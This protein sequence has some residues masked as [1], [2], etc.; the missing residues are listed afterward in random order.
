M[1][2]QKSSASTVTGINP[3]VRSTPLF[4]NG[5]NFF[6]STAAPRE[7]P[8]ASQDVTVATSHPLT[9]PVLGTQANM[10]TPLNAF[11][12][13]HISPRGYK[14]ESTINAV[15]DVL[16]S[17]FSTEAHN[18]TWGSYE[19]SPARSDAWRL[20]LGLPQ[21][22]QT[23][24]FSQYRPS[25]SSENK[26]YLSI[27]NMVQRL[28]YDSNP[29]NPPPASNVIRSIVSGVQ[30]SGGRLAASDAGFDPSE[31]GEGR[32]AGSEGTS[33]RGFTLAVLGRYSWSRGADE[34]GPYIAYYD[35]YDLDQ[36][37]E[38]TEGKFG[39]PFE[40][41]GR[42]YYD[43]QTFEP[44]PEQNPLASMLQSLSSSRSR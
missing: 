26:P 3:F 8:V 4:A 17:V 42:I 33:A 39:R 21:E 19:P 44:L 40:V 6:S 13:E 24:E 29:D 30:G 37:P 2:K 9:G 38:G 16:G 10:R 32:W 1:P 7:A 25:Q 18:R 20:Y 27:K 23:F 43:P 41:Y 15:A 36:S 34:R 14:R 28:R 11:L 5:L 31:Y 12:H 35:R 22:N